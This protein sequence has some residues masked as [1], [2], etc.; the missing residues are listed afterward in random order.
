VNYPRVFA[1]CGRTVGDLA[2]W[3][4]ETPSNFAWNRGYVGGG[5]DEQKIQYLWN[6]TR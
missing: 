5:A 2:Q 1:L 3:K 6:G 4:V